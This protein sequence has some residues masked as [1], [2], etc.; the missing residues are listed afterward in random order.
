M[1]IRYITRRFWF[2]LPILLVAQR[3]FIVGQKRF[4]NVPSGAVSQSEEASTGTKIK[5]ILTEK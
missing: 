2:S 1:S 5:L 4:S 3:A